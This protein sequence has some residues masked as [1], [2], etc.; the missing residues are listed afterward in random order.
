MERPILSDE[1]M[2]HAKPTAP[3]RPQMGR[4]MSCIVRMPTFMHYD[5]TLLPEIQENYYAIQATSKIL[6]DKYTAANLA[7]MDNNSLLN[8]QGLDVSKHLIPLLPQRLACFYQRIYAI[9]LALEILLNGV[10]RAYEPDDK[11]LLDENL[12]LAQE[13]VTLARA[14]ERWK[15]V[16]AGWI[17]ICLVA[18]WTGCTD[19]TMKTEIAQAWQD[20]WQ[21]MMAQPITLAALSSQEYFDGLRMSALRGRSMYGGHL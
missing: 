14:A 4:T 16:G 13:I 12:F 9:Y 1:D 17:P 2:R 11:Q 15:P 3:G 21:D 19:F 18:A 20:V 7:V 6:R 5:P 10:L 8:Y